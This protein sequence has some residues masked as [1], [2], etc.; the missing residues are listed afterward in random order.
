VQRRIGEG[1]L[2]EALA[3]LLPDDSL[4]VTLD[5][6]TAPEASRV[7]YRLGFRNGDLEVFLDPIVVDVPGMPTVLLL[8][9]AWARPSDHTIRITFALPRG[10]SPVVDLIDVAGRRVQKER[11]EGLEPGEQEVQFRL[12]PGTASGI[13]FLRLIQG[14]QSRIAKIVYVR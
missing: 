5:D 14:N 13:Y 2:W 11:F 10:A 4:H 9:A 8:H 7:E 6:R 1:G 12:G 3:S